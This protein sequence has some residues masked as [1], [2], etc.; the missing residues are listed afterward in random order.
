MK[1]LFVLAAFPL[2]M[3]AGC[4]TQYHAQ[5]PYDDVY[6]SSR[7]IPAATSTKVVVK[8]SH[9]P[10]TSDYT[11]AIDQ[12][13]T[14]ADD[15]QTSSAT[16][17]SNYEDQPDGV[18]TESFT[19]PGGGSSITNNFYGDYYDYEYAS[20][21][22]R[23]HSS[24][25]MDSYYDPFY[26][27]MYFYDYNP[28]SW[29]TSIYFNSGWGYPSFGMSYGW[30]WPS[31]SYGWGYSSYGSGYYD[32]YNNGFYNGYWAGN[33]NYSGYYND[34]GGYNNS[35]YY[36]GHRGSSGYR[37][38]SSNGRNNIGDR[39]QTPGKKGNSGNDEFENSRG[40]GIGSASNTE[41]RNS[42]VAGGTST[43]ES[44]PSTGNSKTAN[45]RITNQSQGRTIIP[46]K[47]N[48]RSNQNTQNGRTINSGYRG[49]YIAPAQTTQRKSSTGNF[50]PGRQIS[51]QARNL[52]QQQPVNNRTNANTQNQINTGRDHT[53]SNTAQP[54]K[55]YQQQGTRIQS[56][57]SPSYSKPRSSQEYTTP[58]Y[59][60]IR[61]NDNP[62]S[63]PQYNQPQQRSGSSGSSGERRIETP[64]QT[65][66]QPS[67]ERQQSQPVYSAPIR[68]S[69]NSY[70]APARSGNNSNSSSSPS[71]SSSGSSESSGRPR[72]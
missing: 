36:Y 41:Q 31:Y 22:R 52:N 7:D 8:Q 62:G 35:N 13:N 54:A 48:E 37:G 40:Y 27:N 28:W 44:V 61:S 26:S 19:E 43:R 15:N 60:N 33:G 11:T 2:I 24:Y 32:G 6:Y 56:Y 17:Y 67:Q 69:D 47:I 34:G 25:F 51:P 5:A 29:G 14:Q 21:L 20:R 9:A 16:E 42:S 55:T 72:R 57:S 68:S 53:P 45:G 23:F 49:R 70:S 64:R 18:V 3:A 50:T 39:G 38:G 63:S 4:T 10:V 59:R 30:G 12:R 71:R 1:K 65:T 66:A 46:V 58:K